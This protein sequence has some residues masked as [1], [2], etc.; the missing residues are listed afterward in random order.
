MDYPRDYTLTKLDIEL[1][2]VFVIMP[3]KEE[4]NIIL[5]TINE[6]CENLGI[7]SKRA[8]NIFK[9]NTIIA[10]ILSGIA[11]SEIIIADITGGNPNVFYELGIAH[12]LKPRKS[13]III[14]Q[15]KNI[16]Q[17][18]PFDIRHWSILHYN[19]NNQGAFKTNLKKRIS[20]CRN[21]IDNEEFL[22]HLL[23]SYT[24]ANQLINSFF[25]IAYKISVSNLDSICNILSGHISLE[26]CN[27][28]MIIEL[29]KYLTTLG[30]YNDGI[31]SKITW[32]LKYL[33]Y[34]SDFV[35]S[36]YLDSIKL[37]FLQNWRRDYIK[38]DNTDYWNFVSD[39]CCKIIEKKHE[40]KT[41]A[42]NW[43]TKYLCNA[44]MGR[45]DKVRT[46]IEDF[47]IN[48]QDEEVDDTL[49]TLLIEGNHSVKESAV[50]ICGQK[51]IFKAVNNLIQ[52][53]KNET[54][55]H[56]I[57]SCINALTRMNVVVAGPLILQ[58]MKNNK[59]KWGKQAVSSSLMH[60]AENALKRLDEN[61][62]YQLIKL[63][64]V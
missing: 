53:I 62:Y 59:D 27:R 36:Q 54:D 21:S 5:S 12:T 44:R 20:E 24:F 10:N 1:D 50:D 9:Q 18:T 58:W 3:I 31:F 39:V 23:K 42:I 55:P 15:D 33:V 34:T 14:S 4:Y 2:T 25:E 17:N 11:K 63:K 8:D 64:D 6:V 37:M 45:I 61:S 56:L 51:P 26:R 48:I 32:L 16:S 40:E 57:R 52:M 30:D 49:V 47:L 13:V 7:K 41:C 29:N 28:K 19:C 43:L 38:M 22:S 35:L 46:K 60:V